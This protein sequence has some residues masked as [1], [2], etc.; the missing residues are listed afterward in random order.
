MHWPLETGWWLFLSPRSTASS[1]TSMVAAATLVVT[2]KI[3]AL[4]L[5]CTSYLDT[6]AETLLAS[7]TSLL[8]RFRVYI[9][10]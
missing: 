10:G 2:I 3:Y 1:P 6:Y 9:Y 7:A 8:R 4:L 5:D